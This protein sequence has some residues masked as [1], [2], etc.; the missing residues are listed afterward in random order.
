MPPIIQRKRDTPT[1][2]VI[3]KIPDGVEKTV[4][5]VSRYALLEDPYTYFQYQSSCSR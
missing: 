4:D 3:A 5:N 2:P 1:E